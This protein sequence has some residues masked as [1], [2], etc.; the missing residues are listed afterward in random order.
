MNQLSG[1]LQGV[2]CRAANAVNTE[3]LNIQHHKPNKWFP[4]STWKSFIITKLHNLEKVMCDHN[5]KMTV[6]KLTKTGNWKCP[7]LEMG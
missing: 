1:A 4:S 7:S 6:R 2:S 5:M 3:R